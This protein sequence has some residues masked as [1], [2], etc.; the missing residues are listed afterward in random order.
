MKTWL[1]I[2]AC[3]VI[4]GLYTIYSF[5]SFEKILTPEEEKVLKANKTF[6]VWNSRFGPQSIHYVEQGTGDK[7]IILIHG[8]RA[9]TYT[10]RNIITPLAEA[11]YHVWAIDLLGFG[12]SDKP[13]D[14]G[15]DVFLHLEQIADFMDGM[16]I[17]KAH[18]VGNSMGGGLALG[19]ASLYSEKVQSITLITALGYP[20]ESWSV[21]IGQWLGSWIGP[22]LGP[23]AVRHGLH[24]IVYKTE[25]IT[26]EQVEAYSLPYRLQGGI[27]ASIGVLQSFDN[28]KLKWLH[29]FFKKLKLPILVIWGD[30]DPLIPVSHYQQFLEDFPAASR[31]LIEDCGHIPH[32]EASKE[33]EAAILD[34]LKRT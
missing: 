8:F 29:Q 25:N 23:K 1:A 18:L 19:M 32:E 28:A 6:F 12:L 34:F 27:E 33:V 26:D 22:F 9:H 24:E 16:K 31:C 7:H 17:P 13:V 14:I 5:L 10:W 21:R 30:K 4:Y 15:Y 20:L 3:F 11:G 2:V